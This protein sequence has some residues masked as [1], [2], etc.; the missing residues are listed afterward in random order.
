MQIDG[1]S[2]G[3]KSKKHVAGTTHLEQPQ[4]PLTLHGEGMGITRVTIE[5]LPEDVL[6]EIFNFYRVVTMDTQ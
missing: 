3:S 1:G 4:R 6:L 2:I 5:S